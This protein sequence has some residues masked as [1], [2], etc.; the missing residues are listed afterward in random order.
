MPSAL[1]VFETTDGQTAR[2]ARSV[3]DRLGALGVHVDLLRARDALAADPAG[4]DGV[5]VAAS[6][7]AHRYQ[8]ATI[9][10]AREHAATLA[11]RPTAF[12]TVC[13]AVLE[14]SDKSRRELQAIKERFVRLT[15][16]KPLQFHDVAGALLYTRYG[17]LKRWAMRRIAAK[18]GGDV[19]TSRDYDYTD[20]ADL[21]RFVARFYTTL[22]PALPLTPP[23]LSELLPTPCVLVGAA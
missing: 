19:D 14:D 23:H 4:Y 17:A 11:T 1:I 18:A 2:I 16:W 13:L 8:R 22:Q 10:W 6:I 12:L 5:I 7:H 21:Q 15:N 20:W 9:R 3:A